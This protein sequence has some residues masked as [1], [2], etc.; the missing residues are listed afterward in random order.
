M[1]S[2]LK[3]A[4]RVIQLFGCVNALC[5]AVLAAVFLYQSFGASSDE[6]GML[7][8][9][10]FAMFAVLL[11]YVPCLTLPKRIVVGEVLPGQRWYQKLERFFIEYPIILFAIFGAA[12]ALPTVFFPIEF[13]PWKTFG[14]F[15]M[16][17]FGGAFMQIIA[18]ASKVPEPSQ[19]EISFTI[20]RYKWM[21]KF[22]LEK[23]LY[24]GLSKGEKVAEKTKMMVPELTRLPYSF[25][26]YFTTSE[27]DQE[28]VVVNLFWF[29]HGQKNLCAQFVISNIPKGKKRGTKHAVHLSIDLNRNV[30][31]EVRKP[32]VVQKKVDSIE[33]VRN[34]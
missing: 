31:C 2:E 13:T 24:A 25:S 17:L 32:L 19:T 1:K 30:D 15:I 5:C 4:Y 28:Q 20:E 11:F 18:F 3:T 29:E 21:G 33:P 12:L 7:Q 22:F 8:Y 14:I 26:T 10:A 27:D 16:M 6:R 9:L 23:S 34:A